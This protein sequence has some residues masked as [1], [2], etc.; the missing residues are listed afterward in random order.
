VPVQ[1]S[2]KLYDA[3]VKAGVPAELHVYPQ[4]S[5]GSSV[6]PQY[7]PTAE[8]PKRMEE[9]MRFNGWLPHTN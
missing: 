1:N 8:W 7:G 9:W 2:L 3:L 6:D 4:G 5:H